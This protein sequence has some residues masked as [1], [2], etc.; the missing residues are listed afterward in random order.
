MS[1]H[2]MSTGTPK[3]SSQNPF[4]SYKSEFQEPLWGT[5]GALGFWWLKCLVRAI[6]VLKPKLNP[7]PIQDFIFWMFLWQSGY[8]V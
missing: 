1:V 7:K 8:G 4:R 5:K 6:L 3:A 2:V